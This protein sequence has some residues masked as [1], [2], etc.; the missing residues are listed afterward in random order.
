MAGGRRDTPQNVCTNHGK[1]L[2]YF[3]SSRQVSVYGDEIKV[4]ALSLCIY[5]LS[6]SS[7]IYTPLLVQLQKVSSSPSA[8]IFEIFTSSYCLF[9]APSYCSHDQRAMSDILRASQTR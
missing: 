8:N 1:L 6:E 3:S 7:E 5:F 9:H 4:L 2:I